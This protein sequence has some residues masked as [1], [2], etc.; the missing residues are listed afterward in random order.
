MRHGAEGTKKMRK[1]TMRPGSNRPTVD[2]D[3]RL[4]LSVLRIK[5][6]IKPRPSSMALAGK[7]RLLRRKKVRLPVDPFGC[8][9][10]PLSTPFCISIKATYVFQPLMS[11]LHL[12]LLLGC[13]TFSVPPPQ[14]QPDEHQSDR[15]LSTPTPS[16]AA[17][18]W[19]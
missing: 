14:E 9:S 2:E 4:N 3:Y 8:I 10:T 13:V 7:G 15:P 12:P 1:S 6:L 5:A 17:R 18:P 19:L 16:C 11:K